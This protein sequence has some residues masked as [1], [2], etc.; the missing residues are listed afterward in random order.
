[1]S[2]CQCLLAYTRDFQNAQAND[3][4][5]KFSPEWPYSVYQVHLEEIFD[6][7]DSLRPSLQFFSHVGASLPG[8]NQY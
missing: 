8:L 2:D 5:N 1:M 6:C 4:A 3:K 7:F